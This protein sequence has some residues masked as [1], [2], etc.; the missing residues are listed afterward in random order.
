M[1]FKAT[2]YLVG[3]IVLGLAALRAGMWLAGR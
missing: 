2:A 3:S 1:T